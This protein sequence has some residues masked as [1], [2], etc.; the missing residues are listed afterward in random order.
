MGDIRARAAAAK[1]VF[2][3]VL[4]QRF[5]ADAVRNANSVPILITAD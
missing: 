5:V 2:L 1:S 3:T 4:F